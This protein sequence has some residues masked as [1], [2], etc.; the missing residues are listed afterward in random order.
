MNVYRLLKLATGKSVPLWAKLLGLWGLHLGGRRHI[1]VFLD[2]VLACNL[3]C[4]MCLFSD[5]GARAKM[6][7]VISPERFE[8]VRKAFFKRAVKLQIGCAAEPTLYPRLAEIVKAGRADGVPY[9]SLITNGQ[10]IASGRVSLRELVASGLDE[11]TVSLHGTRAETYEYLMPG[12]RFDNFVELLRQIRDVKKDYPGFKT[13]V[14]FTVNSMN[15]DDLREN[16]F[17]DIWPEGLLPDI[18][19]LRP[20]QQL[21]ECEWD[22]F[23]PAP[24]EAAFDATIGNV[25][26]IC[27]RL[28]ITVLAPDKSQLYEVATEQDGGSAIIENINYCYVSAASAYRDDFVL[29]EEDYDGYYRRTHVSRRLLR[30]VFNPGSFS[31][32][33][34]IS[35]K[36]NYRVK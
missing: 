5:A 3:R 19:Q 12:G 32:R 27:R 1:G 18:V 13:R 4:R 11:I 7:G 8:L 29:G 28:G 9:I 26:S 31:R 15:V 10:L 14:N 34:H 6:K 17:F 30:A 20:V 22:D 24:L 21:G 16:R 33:R 35:K 36:L 25:A 23:D 2:P